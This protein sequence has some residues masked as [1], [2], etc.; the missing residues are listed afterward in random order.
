MG[1]LNQKSKFRPDALI[2]RKE[3]VKTQSNKPKQTVSA[4][5]D[6]L[7]AYPES[8]KS[9]AASPRLATVRQSSASPSPLSRGNERRDR[10]RKL[11]VGAHRPSPAS[12]R[13]EFADDSASDEDGWEAALG[14]P[15]RRRRDFRRDLHRVLPSSA[16][17]NTDSDAAKAAA[18]L[19]MVHAADVAFLS[20]QCRPAL[21]ADE[22]DVAVELQYPGWSTR[23]RYG[24]VIG[25]RTV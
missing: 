4:S 13:V 14:A 24:P 10:K 15:K 2:I 8:S 9:H 16:I 6:A 20:L 5:R 21:A 17:T 7:R 23:E 11:G 25:V 3:T 18:Q 19:R 12:D 1:V 22:S